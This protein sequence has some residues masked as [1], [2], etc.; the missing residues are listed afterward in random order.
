MLRNPCWE[1]LEAGLSHVY[2]KPGKEGGKIGEYH[3][4]G[5]KNLAR[6]AI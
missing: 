1:A 5:R 4:F 3:A 2:C 6:L